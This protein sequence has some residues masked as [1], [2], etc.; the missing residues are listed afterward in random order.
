ME[1]IKPIRPLILAVIGLAICGWAYE[2]FGPLENQVVVRRFGLNFP[3]EKEKAWS[4]LWDHFANK[5]EEEKFSHVSGRDWENSFKLY[6]RRLLFKA[7]LKLLDTSSLQDC[8]TV[9]FNDAKTVNTNLVYLPV[10]AYSTKQNSRDVW[11]IVVKW[12]CIGLVE[13]GDSLGH[14][15]LFAC[16]AKNHQL[17]GFSTC[18]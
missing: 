7:R 15:R 12:E 3:A 6:E 9:V 14:V 2:R 11:I 5:P 18:M 17:I 1:K 16:D 13:N 8:L 10:G 4:F